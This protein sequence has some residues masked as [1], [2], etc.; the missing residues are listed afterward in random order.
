MA[1]YNGVDWIGQQIESILSQK[2]VDV[3]VLI[4][5]D[6]SSDGTYELCCDIASN[7]Q[8]VSI[9]PRQHRRQLG[10][11]G[12]FYHLIEHVEAQADSFYA[13]SDQDDIWYEDKL[14][15]QL[16]ILEDKKAAAISSDV[17]CLWPDGSQKLITKSQPQK[18][19]DFFFESAG[20]G[21]TFCFNADVL[22]L[23]Q[24]VLKQTETNA[25]PKL[26]D[27]F[28]Y[29]LCRAHAMPWVISSKPT[30]FYRQHSHN[31][32]GAHTGWPATLNRLK[33]VMK[34]AYRQ[35]V[36]KIA[37]IL[38]ALDVT[39][40]TKALCDR[41]LRMHLKDRLYLISHSRQLRRRADESLALAI[42]MAGF[43][44]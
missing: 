16:E 30:L 27:W 18:Q 24:S 32:V 5:D 35:E 43:V 44:Y 34:G 6:N 41:L 38:V 13:L 12:N 4:S 20:P 26:H 29:A 2:G 33:T 9:L 40:E 23:A 28:I 1:T 19:F 39:S 17:M 11:A 22:S 3:R 15:S 31:E 10:P 14:A 36:V 25:L 42:M 7:D 37:S 8:R 21:C